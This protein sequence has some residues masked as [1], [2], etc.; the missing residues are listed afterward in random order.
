MSES[1]VYL[2]G[3]DFSVL[4]EKY[5]N[6]DFTNLTTPLSVE[7]S[8]QKS[9][10]VMTIKEN[11]IDMSYQFDLGVGQNFACIGYKVIDKD[12]A[13]GVYSPN[14]EYNC[15]YCL[16]KIKQ[17]PIGIPVRREEKNHKIYFHMADIFCTFNCCKAETKKRQQNAL[18]SQSLVYLAEIYNKCTGKDFSNLK[19]TDQ[20]LLKIFNGPMSW[21][22]FHSDTVTYSEK[23]GNVYFLPIVE[24][25][26]QAS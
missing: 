16:R 19:S 14:K 15:M 25:L 26:E 17:K 4:L 6:G 2:R 7:S 21:E 10:S 23:P 24:F 18:Y 12:G 9:Q 8:N 3:V 1:Q 22:E 11:T 13:Y 5:L 20:R